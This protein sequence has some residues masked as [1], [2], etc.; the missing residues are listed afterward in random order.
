LA[1]RDAGV[2]WYAKLHAAAVTAYALSSIDV[3]P[4][5]I[6]V[7]GYFDDLVIVPLGILLVVS[8]IPGRHHGGAPANGCRR[9]IPARQPRH[10]H[11][12]WNYTIKSRRKAET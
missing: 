9:R 12:Q 6:S 11:P 2:P 3:I 7:V 5:F 1:S 4:D 8:L 10:R